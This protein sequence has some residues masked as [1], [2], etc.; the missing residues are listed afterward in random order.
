[1][2]RLRLRSLYTLLLAGILLISGVYLWVNTYNRNAQTERAL[3]EYEA[4]LERYELENVYYTPE[5][6]VTYVRIR[7]NPTGY[8]VLNPDCIFEP[9]EL[10]RY[11][12]KTTRYSV[13]TLDKLNSIN[14]INS[15][16]TVDY[17]MSNYVSDI[18]FT[19]NPDIGYVNY[20][21]FGY[22]GYAGFRT[23]PD[24]WPGLKTTMDALMVLESLDALD[25]SR[26][27]LTRVENFILAHQNPDGGFWDEDYGSYGNESTLRCTASA[28]RALG[29]IYQYQE[30][31]FDEQF[32]NNVTG[33]IGSC[34]DE[35]DGGYANKPG[36][37]STEVYGTFRAFISLWWFGGSNEL[38]RRA[39]VEENM[40]V[41]RSIEYLFE[42]Y[43]NP[44]TGAFFRY[45][46][47]A[48]ESI[49]GTH[50]VVWFLKDMGRDEKL[51]IYSLGHYIM[52]N[53][54]NP[55]QYGVD[56]HSTYAAVWILVRLEVPTES[57]LAPEKPATT[58]L[59]YPEFLSVI[60]IVLGVLAL[61]TSYFV[62]KKGKE[63]LQREVTERK[64]MEE[65]LQEAYSKLQGAKEEAERANQMKSI[66]L[67]SMSHELRTPLNSI[68]GFTGIILQGLAGELND[69]QK[70]QLEMVYGSSKH[71]LALIN[72]LLD[73]SKI[74]SG[75]LEPDLGEFN[76][77]EAGME[78]RDSLMPNAEE[79]GIKLIWDVPDINVVSDKRRFKQI[80]VNLVNN[81][82]KFTEKGKV[83]VKAIK[84]DKNIEIMVKDTGIGIK[85]EDLH[86]LFEPFTQLEYTVS[87]EKG[88][89]LGL[90]LVRNLVRLLKGDIRV[91]SEYGK[92]ST[93]TFTLS[94]KH[95]G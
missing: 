84:K 15:N 61:G 16:A 71:L 50:L 52:N 58:I 83:E 11:A 53:E 14:A 22:A 13:A 4:A 46:D 48:Q 37:E 10:S 5:D 25:D 69:E 67:A 78:V 34:L 29:R 36:G 77:A 6:I 18:Q 47:K 64:K 72:D 57:L 60:F 2:A 1:M 87:E 51:D 3:S 62:E 54:V 30:R 21:N 70:K 85:K 44:E 75:E 43:Y 17:I 66:F 42:N 65:M 24:S 89:G 35:S 74:E 45:E 81:A 79:K 76:L 12:M 41:E 82:I 31:E 40:D 9:S 38:E 73:I 88:T 59:G 93:F 32:K 92:G 90:Y 27:N 26:L 23:L 19:N 7:Q 33:F 20:S 56:I 8:F 86:K 28:M 94:L 63:E 80:L 39:F 91:E 68:I 55:G 49:K 95:G